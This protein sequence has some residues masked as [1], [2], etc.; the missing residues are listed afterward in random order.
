M[1]MQLLCVG[2]LLLVGTATA[3][4]PSTPDL[5]LRGD[6]F[7]PLT[8]G[9]LNP[10][11]KAL[12]DHVLAGE[13]A[14]LS[15]PYNVFLRSPKMADLAQQLGAYL[16]YHSALSDDLQQLGILITARYWTAQFEW[17]SHHDLAIKSG[18]SQ[19]MIDELAAGKRPST[20]TP[21]QSVT[22]DFCSEILKT[23]QVSDATFRAAVEKLGEQKVVDLIGL[24]GYYDLVSMILNTD[25]YPL[26]NGEPLPLKPLH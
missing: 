16:R 19:K 18:I 1:R 5:H 20:M 24:M 7:R 2:A 25:R 13:R 14:S 15:G 12:A 9:E 26:P 21:E 3:Q 23:T 6:R 8:Y 4:T 22:Y 17:Y 11:Q 10:E